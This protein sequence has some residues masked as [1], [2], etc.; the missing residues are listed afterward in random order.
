MWEVI[1]FRGK[2]FIRMLKQLSLLYHWGAS[3]AFFMRKNISPLPYKPW[4]LFWKSMGQKRLLIGSENTERL[5]TR[6]FWLERR[7]PWLS[8]G[9]CQYSVLV[10]WAKQTPRL[11]N[12]KSPQPLR[13][14]RP[15]SD[16]FTLA[17]R[18]KVQMKVKRAEP[19]WYREAISYQ[20]DSSER[21]LEDLEAI[22]V[23][24]NVVHFLEMQEIRVWGLILMK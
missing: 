17:V 19:T 22:H 23:G 10:A 6:K 24:S 20:L 16:W 14:S 13:L 4:I 3:S 5:Q 2:L 9:S 11:R 7:E 15:A 21:V 18:G 8:R 1:N 12:S